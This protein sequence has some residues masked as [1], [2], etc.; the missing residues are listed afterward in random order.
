MAG[1]T[2]T[3]RKSLLRQPRF[4]ASAGAVV[5][6]ALGL[7]AF[8]F[9]APAVEVI[10][11]IRSPIV[12]HLST[13]GLVD[14]KMASVGAPAPGRVEKIYCKEG[15][16]VQSGQVLARVVP[17]PAAVVPGL[18]TPNPLG[19][20]TTLST[21]AAQVIRAP[22]DG[23]VARK[24]AEEG[25]TVGLGQPVFSIADTRSTWVTA[26]VD[27][28][29]LDKLRLGQRVQV[30]LPTYLPAVHWGTVV[31]IGATA[32]PRSPAL[33]EARVVRTKVALDHPSP[34]LKPGIEVNVEGDV[35]MR[36]DCLIV[37][38]D[39]IVE[40]R[41]RRFVWRVDGNRVVRSE[42]QTGATNYVVSE[43]LS[44]LEEG[45]R[46]ALTDTRK[47]GEAQRIRPRAVNWSRYR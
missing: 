4:W 26:L 2:D 15:N 14:A 28:A 30:S 13:T 29:D 34:Q 36:D 9:S 3:T 37:P 6:A 11:A 39:G 16:T 19:P 1:R 35:V 24:F 43:I 44:G 5:I 41:A 45:D 21:T 17:S 32:E 23:A 33:A 40:E 46:V 22:F 38:C 27:D 20:G 8:Y 25:D 10:T 42:I 12:A 7:L 47:L 18:G 31:Q